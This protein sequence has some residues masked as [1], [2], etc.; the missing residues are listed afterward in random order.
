MAEIL[1]PKN[2]V[3]GVAASAY[4]IEGAWNEDGKGPSIWDT[5]SHTPGKIANGETG[6]VSIDHYHRYKEDVARMADLGIPTYRF[7][8]AWPRVMPE[9]SG[10]VNAKGLAFYDRLVD[11]LLK[12][13]IEPYLCLFHWDLPQALQ[14][15]GGWPERET[16]YHFAKYARI[17]T[18]RLSDRV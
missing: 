12:H 16:A 9:G 8:V 15:K 3:W 13:K 4:Q 2:F 7:S 18:A 17:I 5:F 11:T 14:D 6:D 10:K 1:F